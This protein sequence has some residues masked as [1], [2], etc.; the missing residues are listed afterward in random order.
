MKRRM[1]GP[2]T[3]FVLFAWF[4]PGM[5]PWCGAQ[6]GRLT[7]TQGKE[8]AFPTANRTGSMKDYR[9]QPL[10]VLSISVFQE[11]DLEREEVP[12]SQT[13]SITFPLIGKIHIVGLLI[14]EVESLL[15]GKLADGYLKNPQV[16]V[17]I[18]KYSARRVSV[19]GEVKKPGSFE[20]P[21]EER[22]T[23]LQAVARAEG[24]TNLA[25]TDKVV[26][27]RI[28]DGK[29]IKIEI[30]ATELLKARGDKKDPEL[31]PGDTVVI[32]TRF[33]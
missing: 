7:T 5:A 18:K 27:R 23:F 3:L 6:D 21:A 16:S 30:N 32:P 2:R 22:M 1:L 24:F 11:K 10:D 4:G 17:T 26:I 15:A 25:Q 14:S 19:I 28:R 33:F 20:I 12:V 13:G 9:I 8:T 31:E 29:E